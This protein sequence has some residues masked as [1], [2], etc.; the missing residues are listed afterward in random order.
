MAQVDIV[1]NNREYRITCDDGQEDRLRALAAHFDD[2]VRSLSREL[3]AITDARLFLLSAM[4]VCD[5]LFEA[6][7][8]VRDLENAGD[9]LDPETEGA[10]GR[11]VEAAAERVRDI[12]ARLG[13]EER[14]AA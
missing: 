10:A 4:L 2:H 9:A 5:E 7:E 6:R 11:A 8:R 14:G 12:A 3:G 1:V 13:V